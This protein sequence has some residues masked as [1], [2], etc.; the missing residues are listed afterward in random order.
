MGTI[1]NN[2]YNRT[3]YADLQTLIRAIYTDNYGGDFV[4]DPATPQGQQIQAFVDLM[5]QLEDDK[6]DLNNF[7]DLDIATGE[8]LDRLGA[9]IGIPRLSGSPSQVNTTVTSSTTGFDIPADTEFSLLGETDIVYKVENTVAITTTTQSVTLT[10]VEN[11]NYDIQA[12]DSFETVLS[13]PEI[14]DIEVDTYIDGVDVEDDSD[15]L[16]RIKLLRSG[17]YRQSGV[18]RVSAGLFELE[19]VVDAK[20]YDINNYPTLSNGEVQA[21]VLGGD[22]TEIA[23][24]IL[25]SLDAGIDTVGTS[26]VTVQDFQGLN[27]DINFNPA[28]ELEIGLKLIYDLKTATDLTSAQIQDIKDRYIAF[29]NDY[30]INEKMATS[31]FVNIIVPIYGEQIYINTIK[32]VEA[33]TEKDI[34]EPD[35]FSYIRADEADLTVEKVV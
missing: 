27:V 1:T 32:F 30:K 34:I 9:I 25:D 11:L 28:T 19:N 17:A 10:S 3:S 7:F 21:V 12:G 31:D 26:T 2:G 35:V 5:S 6:V 20:V 16:A 23:N 18:Q 8:C 14:L 29:C 13:F 22:N 24:S 15:Y 33:T 4:V